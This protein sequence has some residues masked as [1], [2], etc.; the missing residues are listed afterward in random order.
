MMPYA[1]PG[2]LRFFAAAAYERLGVSDSDTK[3]LRAAVAMLAEL[4]LPQ[5]P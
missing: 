1:P 2:L 3:M 4:F 5:A